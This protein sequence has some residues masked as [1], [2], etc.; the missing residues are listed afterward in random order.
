M[1]EKEIKKRIEKESE[2][3]IL[4]TISIY[5]SIAIV[6]IAAIDCVKS[7]QLRKSLESG[8]KLISDLAKTGVI[9]NKGDLNDLLA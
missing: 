9:K 2:W 4:K 8:N 7:I 3:G 1:E 6:S 5:L